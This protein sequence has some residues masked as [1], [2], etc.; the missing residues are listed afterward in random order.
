VLTEL[1][2][3][4]GGPSRTAALDRIHIERNSQ[5][6]WDAREIRTALAEGR[7]LDELSLQDGDR[8]VVPEIRSRGQTLRWALA[9]IPPVA[10]LVVSLLRM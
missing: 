6:L 3:L 9:T 1:L 8:I 10:W 7:T 4:A 2:T 5:R